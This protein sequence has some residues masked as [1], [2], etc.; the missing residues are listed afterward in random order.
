M[1]K[2]QHHHPTPH[3]NPN[4]LPLEMLPFVM[5]THIAF[6]VGGVL[7]KVD[8]D[9]NKQALLKILKSNTNSDYS[10]KQHQAI[11]DQILPLWFSESDTGINIFSKYFSKD[12]AKTSISKFVSLH[13]QLCLVDT[14]MINLCQK[15]SKNYQ[16]GIISNLAKDFISSS[17]SIFN[18][19]FFKP[20]IYS[21]NVSCRKPDKKIFEIFCQQANCQF[22]N[23]LFI[24]DSARIVD[25]ANNFG[26]NSLL[27]T[28]QT[29]LELD[30]KQLGIIKT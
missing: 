28:D 11:V 3:P 12:I 27:F 29:K 6:D 30:L 24:D 7:L 20:I 16:I 13:R 19:K 17:N 14:R 1:S 4:L 5:I 25:A 21:G 18:F 23:L 26:I 8:P 22:D 2:H 9:K 10:Q 15:L